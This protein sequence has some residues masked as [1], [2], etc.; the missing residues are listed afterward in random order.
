MRDNPSSSR[1]RH[2]ERFGSGLIGLGKGVWHMTTLT[3][4]K[5]AVGLV[6]VVSSIIACGDSGDTGGT[7][8]G[9]SSASGGGAN[10]PGT[11]FCLVGTKGCVC[12]SG[13]CAS[14]LVCT[15]KTCCDGT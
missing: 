9:G 1:K 6:L 5:S 15:N 4:S 11:N 7:G 8:S 10:G 14:G 12:V 3:S 13:N 2:D